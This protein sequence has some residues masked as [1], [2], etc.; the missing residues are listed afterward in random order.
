[1]KNDFDSVIS[2]RGTA[3]V[4]W[5]MAD[6]IYGTG[7]IL[8]LWVADMDFPVPA[9]VQEAVMKR[10]AHGIYGYSAVMPSC[11]ESIITWLRER[12]DWNVEREWLVITP[13][14]VPAINMMIQEFSRQGDG[15][16]IQE[17]VYYPFRNAVLNNNRT[18]VNNPLR[19]DKGRYVMDLRDLEEKIGREGAAMMILCSPHNPVG[20]VWTRQELDDLSALCNANNILVVSDEIHSDLVFSGKKHFP[21][22][23]L[24]GESNIRSIVCHAPSKTFNMPGLQVSY[25][26]IPDSDLRKQFRRRLAMNGIFLSNTFGPLAMEAAYQCGMEWLDEVMTYIEENFR[27]LSRFM[28]EK[29]PSVTI[30]EPDA[31]YLVWMDFRALGLDRDSLR[32]LLR[33]KA[34]VALDEGDIFG[35]GGEGFVRIN[36]ACPRSILAEALQRIESALNREQ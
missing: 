33:Q 5:D 32:I 8:P 17:P 27:Y 15:V 24:S 10:A 30:I 19:L 12:H 9:A 18:L 22:T 2:R 20:R 6:S 13:G 14:V 25:A 35:E 4:K 34:G 21:Y 26:V 1:M 11:Y 23:A 28:K 3:S 29:L 31:T 36:I 16:I 7:D